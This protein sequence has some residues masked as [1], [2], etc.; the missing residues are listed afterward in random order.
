MVADAGGNALDAVSASGK[1]RALSIFPNRKATF[2]G[3]SLVY[4]AV[5]T[6]VV[7]APDGSLSVGQLTGFPFP[8]GG[9]NV[10]RVD[11]R[12]GA[13]SILARGFTNIMDLAYSRG[14]TLYVLEID[15][16]GLV[17]P[18]SP[19]GAIIAVTKSG[20][21]RAVEL[22]AGT[23]TAPGGIAVGRDGSLY[24]TN[25]STEPA[26]GSVLRIRLR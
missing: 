23:L 25:A 4:Q 3:R 14:G 1:V 2:Q 9:A 19:E 24:V 8:V 11:R 15:S 22:P 21:Q 5:P 20:K 26:K 10:Y 12:T 16:N 7:G 6:S 13:H 18:G 17:P